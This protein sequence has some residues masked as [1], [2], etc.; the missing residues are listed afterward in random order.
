MPFPPDAKRFSPGAWRKSFTLRHRARCRE[1]CVS[2]QFSQRVRHDAT[3]NWNESFQS[4]FVAPASRRLSCVALKAQEIAAEAPV[5][6]RAHVV[7]ALSCWSH[8][9]ENDK[10]NRVHRLAARTRVPG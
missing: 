3:P 6:R 1:S 5:L 8:G 2:L 9:R 10:T 4:G 7:A